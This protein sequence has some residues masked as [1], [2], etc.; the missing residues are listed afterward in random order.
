MN[1]IKKIIKEI[2]KEEIN[3]QQS[4]NKLLSKIADDL[5]QRLYCDRHGSCVHFAELFVKE[6]H[7]TNPKLLDDFYVVE[8]YVDCEIG[9]GIP[10]EHTWIELKDGSKIDP[11]FEQFT[12]YGWADYMNKIARKY[13]GSYYYTETSKGSW[14]SKRREQYPDYIF[15]K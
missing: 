11:T 13:K 14:F 15:K 5:S 6:V 10:Q 4:T 7:K 9:D 8:G 1:R 12:N 2:I 3:N